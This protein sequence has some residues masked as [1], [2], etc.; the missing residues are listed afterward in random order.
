ML[1]ERSLSR[2]CTGVSSV[3]FS[4]VPAPPSLCC[5]ISRRRR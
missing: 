5:I 3:V 2:F 1:L 4:R